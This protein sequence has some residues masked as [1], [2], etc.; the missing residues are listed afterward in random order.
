MQ[1]ASLESRVSININGRHIWTFT[2]SDNR[3]ECIFSVAKEI[4]EERLLC[5][6]FNIDE[7]ETADR[8]IEK[9]DKEYVDYYRSNDRLVIYVESMNLK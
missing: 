3:S 5:I 9:I 8:L 4:L 2:P 6:Q 7:S 1:S